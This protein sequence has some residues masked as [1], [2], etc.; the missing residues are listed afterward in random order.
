MGK[1]GLTEGA[2]SCHQ[3]ASVMIVPSSSTSYNDLCGSLGSYG[4]GFVS[5]LKMD[6]LRRVA[7]IDDDHTTKAVKVLGR[8]M[9]VVP[10]SASFGEVHCCESKRVS[11]AKGGSEQRVTD[12]TRR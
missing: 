5:S 10:I 1:V 12:S 8:E 6:G 2:G 4:R 9:G 11:K 7:Y 3:S